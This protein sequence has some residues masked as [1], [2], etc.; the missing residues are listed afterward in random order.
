MKKTKVTLLFFLMGLVINGC[1][2]LAADGIPKIS[3][4]DAKKFPISIEVAA[5]EEACPDNIMQRLMHRLQFHRRK[6][7]TQIE[8]NMCYVLLHALIESQQCTIQEGKNTVNIAFNILFSEKLKGYTTG[9]VA[10]EIFE[11][12]NTGIPSDEVARICKDD[13]SSTATWFF[14]Q[15]FYRKKTA[16][17]QYFFGKDGELHLLRHPTVSGV[18]GNYSLSKEEFERIKGGNDPLKGLLQLITL[19]S[20][21]RSLITERVA[22][23]R[24]K[25]LADRQAPLSEEAFGEV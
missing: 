20:E 12:G 22:S 19:N 5:S 4:E 1:E 16:I 7:C 6:S 10:R 13:V 3:E 17:G 21:E 23:L 11:N 9:A 15:H 8:Q 14:A 25:A 2:V 18:Q 24:L